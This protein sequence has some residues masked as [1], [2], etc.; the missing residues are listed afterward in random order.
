MPGTQAQP[1]QHVLV[2]MAE[3]IS[4][5]KQVIMSNNKRGWVNP[6]PA[7]RVCRTPS[8]KATKRAHTLAIQDA[9]GNTVA[10]ILSSKDGN[11][12]LK[13]GAK[14]AIV[15]EYPTEIVDG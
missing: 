3:Y 15:T 1:L 9:D 8:G 13:C 12:V 14:V 6:A 7:I 10:T 4:V 2:L 5:C 11:P